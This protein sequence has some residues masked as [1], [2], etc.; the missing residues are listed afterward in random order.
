M[1]KPSKVAN[2]LESARGRKLV[3]VVLSFRNEA[4]VLPE[5]IRRLEAVFETQPEDYELVFVN[6]DSTD[7]SLQVLT[8]ASGRNPR[9][10]VVTMSRRF[11]VSECAIAG[12]AYSSGDAVVYM[13]ADLQD[14]PELIPELLAKWRDQGV[15]VVYTVRTRRQAESALKMWLTR[16]AYRL[17]N[18]VSEVELPV[19]AGDF[20]LI[21]R[22]ALRHLLD[23]PESDPYL[24]GLVQ[25]VGFRQAPV[26]Y[27]RAPRAGGKGHFPLLRS[28]GPIKTFMTG[29]TSFSFLPLFLLFGAGVGI[30]GLSLAG[31]A[32]SG[33]AWAAGAAGATATWVF[34]ALFL[35]ATLLAALGMVGIYVMRIYKDVRGRPRYIVRET[36]GITPKA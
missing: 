4:D 11:G 36:I 25:W 8:Q 26:H 24:R 1:G 15:D 34:L 2:A 31:F 23:L 6:D 35:W 10:K 22:R 17:I 18:A 16:Q 29:M 12:F 5:L 13:D 30:S 19:N 9:I 33:L 14:P 3:S 32:V 27:E 21:D 28:T 7:A 20:R